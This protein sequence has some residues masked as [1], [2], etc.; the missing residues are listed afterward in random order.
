M[1]H[2]SDVFLLTYVA[3]PKMV[4]SRILWFVAPVSPFLVQFT[5]FV[6]VTF[7]NVEA[8]GKKAITA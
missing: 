6:S 1:K 5:Q 7:T 2:F 4:F 3:V 8:C